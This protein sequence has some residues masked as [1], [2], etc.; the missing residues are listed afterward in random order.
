MENRYIVLQTP[1]GVKF[2]GNGHLESMGPGKDMIVFERAFSLS[3]EN[4]VISNVV[5]GAAINIGTDD[6]FWDNYDIVT[7]FVESWFKK[8]SKNSLF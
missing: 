4:T 3:A 7:L 5:V 6:K 8:L 2:C 1:N